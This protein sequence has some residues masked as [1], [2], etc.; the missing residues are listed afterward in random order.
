MRLLVLLHSLLL[1]LLPLLLSIARE[2]L[3]IWPVGHGPSLRLLLLL[4]HLLR[5]LLL[6]VRG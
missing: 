6:V 2:L 3:L 1:R 4:I 5:L